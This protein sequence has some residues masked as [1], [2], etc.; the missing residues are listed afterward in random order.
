MPLAGWSGSRWKQHFRR[1]NVVKW[2]AQDTPL[3]GVVF[4]AAYPGI[5]RLPKSPMVN[6]LARNVVVGEA[7]LLRGRPAATRSPQ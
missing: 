5:G 2:V 4:T 6:Y 3:T 1:P 7:A